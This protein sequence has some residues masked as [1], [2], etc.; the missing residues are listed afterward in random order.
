MMVD[1][2]NRKVQ[3]KSLEEQNNKLLNFYRVEGFPTIIL[4]DPNGKVVGETGY[5]DGGAE[6]YVA[7]LKALLSEKL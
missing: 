2:P 4:L 5:R 6:A 1:F 7:Y 3:S